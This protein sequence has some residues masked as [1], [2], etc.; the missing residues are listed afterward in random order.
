MA[1]QLVGR[2]SG[3]WTPSLNARRHLTA[4]LSLALVCLLPAV[5]RAADKKAIAR[6]LYR[7]GDRLYAV[8]EYRN[9][10]ETFK[11]GYLV[12]EEPS[13]LFNMAQCYRQLG[14]KPEAVR[15]YKSYLRKATDD[16][17]QKEAQKI[18]ANLEDAIEQEHRAKSGPP[19]GTIALASSAR[20]GEPA[21]E[22]A[23]ERTDASAERKAG[24]AP[25][26]AVVIAPIVQT[27]PHRRD[28]RQLGRRKLYAGI[29]TA[30]V[31]VLAIGG[32]AATYSL[33]VVEQ[34]KINTATPSHPLEYAAVIEQRRDDY[35][36]AA[37]ALFPVGG[38]AVLVGAV[39]AGLGLRQAKRA[40]RWAVAPSLGPRWAGLTAQISF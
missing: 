4:L 8:G 15:F 27:A 6:E 36:N 34:N 33:A 19:Q 2:R 40:P 26:A 28:D 12:Y 35:Q 22:G 21:P 7:E 10:L 16:L 13:F 20:A 31:G 39:T 11:K 3:K 32:A 30:V 29:A 23:V 25:A 17:H 9:A 24:I 37:R 1:M 14:D 18:V 38:V 5:G